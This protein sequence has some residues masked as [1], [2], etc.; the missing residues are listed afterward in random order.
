[1]SRNHGRWFAVLSAVLTALA[2]CLPATMAQADPPDDVTERVLNIHKYAPGC[3]DNTGKPVA[4]TPD[5][6]ADNTHTGLVGVSFEVWLVPETLTGG[7]TVPS[8][9]SASDYDAQVEAVKAQ[10][11]FKATVTTGIVA[12]EQGNAVPGVASFTAEPGSVGTY[13]VVELS[14]PAVKAP[15]K[16]FFVSL[17]MT[18]P[19]DTGDWLYTV[20]VYPKNE[21]ETGPTVEKD[22][23][24][25]NNDDASHDVGAPQTWIIRGQVP[26][27]LYVPNDLGDPYDDV[28][29]QNYTFN[30]PLD[31]Q[32]TYVG[33]E[34]RL[35]KAGGTEETLEAALYD[36]TDSTVETGEP[37]GTL[38]VS[39][40]DE[41]KKWV[42]ENQGVGKIKPEVRVYVQTAI[43]PT[44]LVATQI[45]NN[46][47]LDYTNSV[48]YTFETA[49]V[50]DGRIPEVH[51]GGMSIWKTDAATSTENLGNAVFEVYRD[52][53]QAET[54]AGLYQELVVDNEPRQVVRVTGFHDATNLEETSEGADDERTQILGRTVD[55]VTTGADGKA[56]VYGLAYGDY[57]LVETQAPTGYNM[58]VDPFVVPVGDTTHQATS[59]M[60]ITN[61]AQF[62]LPVTGGAG[63]WMFT[64]AGLLLLGLAGGG[65]AVSRRRKATA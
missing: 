57:Y 56:Y 9:P 36:T 62:E 53:T 34:V 29:A 23:D 47:G 4:C 46:A 38:V 58:S 31:D 55:V 50:P 8:D 52:A 13:L 64:A 51:T 27:D 35:Y 63:T 14:N 12:D 30:D 65:L 18:D 54:E 11:E 6:L 25:I 21:V 43:N 45:P 7:V 17:P 22:V 48:G 19:S 44:A 24:S 1:M 20:D 2:V 59:I 42:V 3:V 33:M 39:L 32:L 16:P 41:G 15:A 40:N 61:S 49:T 5:Q 60:T 26:A 28:Y 10:S 37:G